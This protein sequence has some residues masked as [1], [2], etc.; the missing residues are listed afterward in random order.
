MTVR[1]A[2]AR[3]ELP[4]FLGFVCSAS[5]LAGLAAWIGYARNA[6]AP[7]QAVHVRAPAQVD[8]TL[9]FDTLF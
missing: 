3:L 4:L 5:A 9:W 8:P 2:W 6:G 7:I 1:G